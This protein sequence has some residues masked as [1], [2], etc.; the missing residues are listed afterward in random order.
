MVDIWASRDEAY[1]I[2]SIQNVFSSTK[3]LT[4]LVVAML[5]D[6]GHLKYTDKIVDVWPEYGQHGKENTTVAMMMRHE[7]GIAEVFLPSLLPACLLVIPIT[8]GPPS[9]YPFFPSHPPSLPSIPPS[10]HS[11]F[12]P[13]NH[14]FPSFRPSSLPPLPPV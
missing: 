5:F 4:S 2:S 10:F 3:V 12:L 13:F 11:T 1:D 8:S 14:H 6:R 9:F 7:C